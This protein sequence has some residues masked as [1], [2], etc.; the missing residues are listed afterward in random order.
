MENEFLTL[1]LSAIY[2]EL[3]PYKR[4]ILRNELARETGLKRTQVYKY[5][6]GRP[7]AAKNRAKVIKA[8]KKITGYTVN[9]A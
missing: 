9:I 6:S 3:P 2:E 4:Q 8:V 7:I 5:L 1:K